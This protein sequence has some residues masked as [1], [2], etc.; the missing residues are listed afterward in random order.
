M[1]RLSVLKTK[2]SQTVHVESRFSINEIDEEKT[3]RWDRN[4]TRKKLKY[5]RT[6]HSVSLFGVPGNYRHCVAMHYSGRDT[7]DAWEQDFLSYSNHHQNVV[8]LFGLTRQKSNPALVFCDGMI[9]FGTQSQE[10]T[11]LISWSGP[12]I[13]PEE[14]DKL[15]SF[16]LFHD[17]TRTLEYLL[18][19]PKKHSFSQQ[20]ITGSP[21][22]T[23]AFLNCLWRGSYKHSMFPITLPQI[24]SWAASDKDS[25]RTVGWF[26]RLDKSYSF[27]VSAWR[28]MTEKEGIQLEHGWTRFHYDITHWGK[29]FSCSVNLPQ[30]LEKELVSAWLCQR[31][32][33]ANATE[34]DMLRLEQYGVTTE[35]MLSLMLDVGAAVLHP[36]IIPKN[37]F[38]FLAPVSLN[39]CPESGSTQA[40][41]MP[42]IE[43]IPPYE[44]PGRSHAEEELDNWHKYNLD[45]VSSSDSEPIHDNTSAQSHGIWF[46]MPWLQQEMKLTVSEILNY[47]DLDLS[48]LDS[49]S[50]GVIWGQRHPNLTPHLMSQS[51]I[52]NQVHGWMVPQS[53]LSAG[54]VLDAITLMFGFNH[55][56]GRG[57]VKLREDQAFIVQS[58]VTRLKIL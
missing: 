31:R 51:N 56:S 48:E 44:D 43:L 53:T 2:L 25:F 12:I 21:L 34:G 27:M 5:T 10:A 23:L 14:L 57:K 8:R 36:N 13:V 49:G 39:Q 16:D 52:L 9:C 38:M 40:C 45:E 50:D 26:K 54:F 32:F 35:V 4:P 6:A 28:S 20:I 24:S 29:N 30:K 3:L 33:V 15:L 1:S 55:K 46:L 19:I 7:Y 18:G 37:I 17:E 42:L 41:G 11:Q 47:Q 22:D 58:R